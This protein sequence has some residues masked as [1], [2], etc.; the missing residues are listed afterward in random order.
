[1]PP[2][3]LLVEVLRL[4]AQDFGSRLP[5]LACGDSFTPAKRLK[6]ESC[7]AHH[8]PPKTLLVEVLRLSAQDFASRLPLVTCGD[9]FTP[10]KRLKFESCMK[11]FLRVPS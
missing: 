1:M 3:T 8:P 10:A 9:S 6:F 7:S 4:S 11:V 5:L 2:K